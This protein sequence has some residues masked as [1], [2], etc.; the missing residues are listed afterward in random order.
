MEKSLG[1]EAI[2]SIV[3]LEAH[4]FVDRAADD[5]MT[6]LA[7][8]PS[9]RPASVDVG[10]PKPRG[11]SALSDDVR[12]AIAAAADEMK[13][14]TTLAYPPSDEARLT[15]EEIAALSALQLPAAALSALRKIVRAAASAPLF[16]M[17]CLL[18]GVGDP[19][20]TR[21]AE[22][23][24]VNLEPAKEGWRAMM[25]DDFLESYW[26]YAKRREEET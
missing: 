22:W 11:P 20:V 26:Q 4:R 3:L 19:E 10:A 12:T 7:R 23:L 9:R 1:H 24:P 16:H 17:F 13:R 25:H 2:A 14:G 21:V 8:V 5:A 18:D 15:D 6:R